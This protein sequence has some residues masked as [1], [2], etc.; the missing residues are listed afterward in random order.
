VRAQQ[1]LAQRPVGEPELGRDVGVRA[2]VD[3]DR[4]QRGALA[5]G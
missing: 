5:V 3:G 4:H 1:Q 2:I